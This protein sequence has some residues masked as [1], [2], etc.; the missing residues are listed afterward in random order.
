MVNDIDILRYRE[1]LTSSRCIKK[2]N[3][4]EREIEQ[5]SNSWLREIEKISESFF[6]L[7]ESRYTTIHPTPKII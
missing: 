3:R 1:T 7:I 5:I 2:Q 6:S 4:E